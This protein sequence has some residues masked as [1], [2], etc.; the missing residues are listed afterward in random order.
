LHPAFGWGAALLIAAVPARIAFAQS[1]AW[2]S[3]ANW[4]IALVR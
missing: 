4:L 3:M 2:I 1:D